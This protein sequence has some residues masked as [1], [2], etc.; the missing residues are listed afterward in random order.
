KYGVDA[1]TDNDRAAPVDR[2][3][4]DNFAPKK[5]PT[6]K[7]VET[8]TKRVG[9]RVHEKAFP[10]THQS[11]KGKKK[12]YFLRHDL[13]NLVVLARND[14]NVVATLNDKLDDLLQDIWWRFCARMTDNSI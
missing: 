8:P 14:V 13:E 7:D 10:L 11:R 6:G 5:K 1:F 12:R 3:S 9:R 4:G 2:A